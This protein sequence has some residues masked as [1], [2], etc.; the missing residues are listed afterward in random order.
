M[1][2]VLSEQWASANAIVFVTCALPYREATESWT[3]EMSR[4]SWDSDEAA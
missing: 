2:W 3:G 1:L 4:Y